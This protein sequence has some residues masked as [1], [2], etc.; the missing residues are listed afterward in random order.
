MGSCWGFSYPCIQLK[1]L[2]AQW[3]FRCCEVFW[4]WLYHAANFVSS[5]QS[6]QQNFPVICFI[7]F[8]LY[9]N[10]LFLWGT[11]AGLLAWSWRIGLFTIATFRKKNGR[12]ISA[13]L[14]STQF[15][16]ISHLICQSDTT[17]TPYAVLW[18]LLDMECQFLPCLFLFLVTMISFS[19]SELAG[20]I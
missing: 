20:K 5:P 9:H 8:L 15:H 18:W 17:H 11:C 12:H 13:T 2:H 6:R 1:F 4:V 14:M 19:G 3:Y 10:C 16:G 7:R